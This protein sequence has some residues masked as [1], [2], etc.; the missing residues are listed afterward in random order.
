MNLMYL[1]VCDVIEWLSLF[2]S[3]FATF[4]KKFSLI[5]FVFNTTQELR[6]YS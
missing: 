4:A 3:E 1:I 2:F 6:K 5:S